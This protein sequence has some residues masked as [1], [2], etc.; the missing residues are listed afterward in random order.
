MKKY[1]S[2]YNEYAGKLQRLDNDGLMASLA[3]MMSGFG[4]GI[5]SGIGG[6]TNEHFL[7]IVCCICFWLLW[8]RI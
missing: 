1:D 2:L 7:M 5:G 6:N 3:S 8:K 4:G